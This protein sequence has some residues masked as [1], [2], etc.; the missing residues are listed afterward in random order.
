MNLSPA[1]ILWNADGSAALAGQ[2]TMANS[3]PVALA[4]NQSNLPRTQDQTTTGTITA[5]NGAVTVQPIGCSSAAFSVTGTWVGTLVFEATVDGTNWFAVSAMSVTDSNLYTTRTTN[6]TYRIL[7]ADYHSFRLRASLWTSGTATVTIIS[8][9]AAGSI[10][11]IQSGSTG[12]HAQVEGLSAPGVLINPNPVVIGGV[13]PSGYIKNAAI[14]SQ[15]R[16]VISPAGSVSS[17]AGF[18]FGFV[19]TATITTVEIKAT[20]YTAQTSNAQRSVVSASA[21]DA[22]AG[23]GARTV[24]IKF[25]DSNGAGPY[26]ATVTLNGTTPVNMV[27]ANFCFLEEMHVA[28]AGSTGSN[29]GIISLKAATA[30]GGVTVA[31]IAATANQTYLSHHYVSSTRDCYITGM[32]V[33][34][35]STVI[36]SGGAYFIRAKPI[37]VSAAI[38]T[39]ISDYVR[40]YG[41]SSTVT[42]VYGTAIQVTGPAY[43][44]Q[45]VSTEANTALVNR[46]SFDFYDQAK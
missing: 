19:S 3:L 6:D 28:T 31:T 30:G 26:F 37:G 14:D 25:L 21:N 42:R 35:T 27:A 32:S 40:L 2:Q 20:T 16:I 4:S 24:V 5:L 23:T 12:L 38:D 11:I 36:G 22:A 18:A 10:G 8:S 44:T 13:D 39:Q 41:Q 9:A 34:S 46:G 43:I 17:Y 33:G 15:G 45:W 29:V 7:V 1:V